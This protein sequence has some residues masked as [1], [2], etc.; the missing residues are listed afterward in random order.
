M[1]IRGRARFTA[2]GASLQIFDREKTD[3]RERPFFQQGAI[4]FCNVRRFLAH[5]R[6]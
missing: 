5:E 4:F 6:V 1:R 2:R 3:L